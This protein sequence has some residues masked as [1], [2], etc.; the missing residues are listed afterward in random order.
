MK[1]KFLFISILC[2]AALARIASS[3]ADQEKMKLE[4]N[5]AIVRDYMNRDDNQSKP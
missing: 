2:V 1:H 3:Q 4:R 5:K